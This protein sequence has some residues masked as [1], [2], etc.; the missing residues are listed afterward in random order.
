MENKAFLDLI[1][2]HSYLNCLYILIKKDFSKDE[3]AV[4]IFSVHFNL[5]L[6][7]LKINIV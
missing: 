3:Y 5:S 1:S 4:A 2:G 7:F 6:L